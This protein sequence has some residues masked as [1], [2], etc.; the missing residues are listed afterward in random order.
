[1]AATQSITVTYPNV[2]SFAFLSASLGLYEIFNI[3]TG[4]VLEDFVAVFPHYIH[5]V[6][7]VVSIIKKFRE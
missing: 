4:Q 5:N 3:N 7:S 1:M 6:Q 2:V